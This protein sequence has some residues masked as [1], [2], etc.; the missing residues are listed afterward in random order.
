MT[1]HFADFTVSS[2]SAHEVKAPDTQIRQHAPE[3]GEGGGWL[4]V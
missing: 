2:A 3:N 1:K 4:L